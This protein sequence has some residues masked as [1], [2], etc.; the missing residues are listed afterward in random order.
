MFSTA[1]IDIPI[2]CHQWGLYTSLKSSDY[3][4]PRTRAIALWTCHFGAVCHVGL[5][6]VKHEPGKIQEIKIQRCVYLWL[7][8]LPTKVLAT[9]GLK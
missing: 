6:L 9:Y 4:S 7:N 1:S 2:S 5:N 8:P 3:S